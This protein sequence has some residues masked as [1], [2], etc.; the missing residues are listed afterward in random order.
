MLRIAHESICFAV[1]QRN[2]RFEQI[3]FA[4][5][6]QSGDWNDLRSFLA[7]ARHGSLQGA[8]R[9]LGVNHSTV[10]RRLNALEARLG[11]RLFDRSPRGYALTVAG[12]H[13]LAS[14]ER[15]ED[16]ILGLE[17]RLLGGDVR[18]SGTLRVTTTDTLVHGLLGPHLRAFQ[19]AYPAI[20]LELI[21]GN[22]FFDLSRR[23]ADVALRPSRHPGD[24]M[25]GR[26]LAEIAV[27]LY[28]ARDYLAARG[29][30]TDVADLGGHALIMGDASLGHLPATR[31]LTERAPAA[32]TVL[33]CNSWLSQ[34]AAACA[35]LGLAALP[36][37]LGDP[38]PELARVLPPEPALA[39]ELWLVTHPDLRRT[40]RVRA[41]M[42]TLARGLR[43][44]R[45]LLEGR[46]G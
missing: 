33:R 15:V 8:A 9:G 11:T 10:F 13:M 22:A 44:E 25:L 1:T 43:R 37:F 5:M 46:G 29:R 27:A 3:G 19:V 36:C 35:G 21:S 24:A 23:E 12:E 28:G 42:D 6:Q 18:L 31:W 20:E 40:A 26:K 45:A 41:F 32:A 34:F 16:E 38:A 7:I 39:G 17:R 30:P 4:A 14:A 2:L